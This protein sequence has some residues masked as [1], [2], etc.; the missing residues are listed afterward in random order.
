MKIDLFSISCERKR[1][2]KTQFLT[3]RFT[4]EGT[5]RSNCSIIDPV[6]LVQK[7]NPSL[8][9]YLYI[10]EFSRFYFIN[11]VESVRNNLWAIS[12]H[13]DVLYTWRTDIRNSMAIIDRTADPTKFNPYL[14][15][16]SFLAEA[17]TWDTVKVFPDSLQLDG[18]YI[19]IAAGGPYSASRLTDERK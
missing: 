12:A 14:D 17:R 9:N 5:L 10:A 19:L 1:V 18:E 13:V 15:D 7:T 3:N 6:I 2:D 11:N 8:Y 16:S 4:L